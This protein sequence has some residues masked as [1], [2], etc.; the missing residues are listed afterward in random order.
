MTSRFDHHDEPASTQMKAV[1]YGAAGASAIRTCLAEAFQ[2]TRT[3]ER[4]RNAP[5][6]AAFELTRDVRLLDLGGDWPTRA[7]ASQAIWSGPRP[8]ARRWSRRIYDQYGSIEGL[9]YP[10]SMNA[11]EPCV[12]LYERARSAIPGTPV[13]NRALADPTL[14]MSLI[15]AANSLGYLLVP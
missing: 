14:T 12:A 7:R 15:A 1:L 5:W 13:F 3:M 9:W 2:A 8:R 10:S 11:G 4:S 6:L